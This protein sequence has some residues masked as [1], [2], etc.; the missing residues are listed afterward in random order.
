[1][2]YHITVGLDIFSLI[3]ARQG[4]SGRKQD[5][6]RQPRQGQT[7]L[8][9]LGGLDK[10]EAELLLHMGRGP[11]SAPPCS[12]VVDSVSGHPKQSRLADSFG[13]LVDSLVLPA[14]LL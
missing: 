7:V 11:M 14:T 6:K 9:L 1:M 13:L 12:L 2:T 8:Q 4:S 3:E 10:E 5:S